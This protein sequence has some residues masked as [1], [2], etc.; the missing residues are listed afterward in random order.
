MTWRALRR[1]PAGLAGA[2][3]LGA[4]CLSVLLAPLL[5]PGDPAEQDL[6]RRLQPPAWAPGGT[7]RHPLGTDALGRDILS[8]VLYG[9]RVSLLIGVV[10]VTLAGSLGLALGLAAGYVGGAADAFIMRLAD[11]QLA[12]P[13]I[14]LAIGLIAAIGPNVRNLI[15]VLGVTG[16]VVYARVIRA[17]VL[18]LRH[19][20]FV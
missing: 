16:W 14:L 15:L 1:N 17:A 20:E 12:I 6:D 3:V 10:G 13:F 18:G 11:V 2:A 9:G 5:A 4:V 19:R 7:W 8:R